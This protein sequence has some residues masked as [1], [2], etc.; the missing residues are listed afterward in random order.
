MFAYINSIILKGE[1][2]ESD[3]DKPKQSNI[4]DENDVHSDPEKRVKTSDNDKSNSFIQRIM[5]PMY[6]DYESQNDKLL[7]EY[8][9]LSKQS[10]LSRSEQSSTFPIYPP[11]YP[12]MN[13]DKKMDWKIFIPSNIASLNA[14]KGKNQHKMNIAPRTNQDI[15]AFIE[16]LD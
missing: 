4:E 13:P 14:E 7:R 8:R 12:P 3:D 10:E 9:N 15:L 11:I 1:S 2:D 6:L 5:F 16:A